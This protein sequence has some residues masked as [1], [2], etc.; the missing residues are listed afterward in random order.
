MRHVPIA[1]VK[2][3]L[4]D[5]AAAAAGGDEIVVTRHRRPYVRLVALTDNG[6]EQRRRRAESAQ[7]LVKLGDKIR[8]EGRGTPIEDI[9]AMINEDG[10]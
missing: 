7:A 10:R 3:K 4:S 1:A 9:V 2:D 5:Y 8:A 6:Q